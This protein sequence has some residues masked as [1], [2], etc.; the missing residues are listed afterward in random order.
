MMEIPVGVD[1]CGDI[2]FKLMNKKGNKLICRW[3]INTSFVDS[4]NIYSLDKRSVDPD[5][6]AKNSSFEAD[7][8]V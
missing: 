6:I 1:L 4:S 3:A 7:F 2:F 8:Q 5:S